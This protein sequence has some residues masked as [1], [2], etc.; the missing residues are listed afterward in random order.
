[1]HVLGKWLLNAL[2][3]LVVAN[4]VPGI[5]IR[6][7]WIAL[8]LAVLWGIIGVTL[9]PLLLILTLPIN[10]LSL[11]LFTFV[12]NG[13]LFWFLSSIVKGFEVAGFSS[14]FVGALT[15]SILHWV[16]H[17]IYGRAEHTASKQ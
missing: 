16:L 8:I 11:G 12:I 4:I 14:A 9:R 3:F 2:V 6:S 7:L 17:W 10:I 13:L 1:M 5:H 15:L